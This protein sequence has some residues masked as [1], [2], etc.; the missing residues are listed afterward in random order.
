MSAKNVTASEPI[1]GTPTMTQIVGTSRN[2]TEA[3]KVFLYFEMGTGD[4]VGGF[5]CTQMVEKGMYVRIQ[6]HVHECT[7]L[8]ISRD[9][10]GKLVI[11]LSP[12]VDLQELLGG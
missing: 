3:H 1:T 7:G 12:I 11:Y 10:G 5:W 9:D 4:P 8:D 6:G 2:V